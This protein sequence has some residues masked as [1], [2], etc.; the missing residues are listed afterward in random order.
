MNKLKGI[1]KSLKRYFR[2][3]FKEWDYSPVLW[4][5]KPSII[6]IITNDVMWKDKD[7]TPRYEVPPYIWIHIYKL[8]LVWYWDLNNALKINP[9]NYVDNY[10]E[11][12][13]WYL[14]YS[15]KNIN[16]AKETW[17]W[18]D[19]RNGISTWSDIFLKK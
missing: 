10:W 6:H 14:Y 9:I 2:C 5:T 16:K 4:C 15:P 8:N 7:N 11:Q 12:A 13:L 3:S 1:F 19:N 18:R 17:P